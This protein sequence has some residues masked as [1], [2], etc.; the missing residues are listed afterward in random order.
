MV[1]VDT[2]VWISH[3]RE[4]HLGLTKLLGNG[5]AACRPFVVG[6]LAFENL[7]NRSTLLSLLKALP[8]ALL[9]DPMKYLCL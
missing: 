7:K 5:E 8:M 1:L 6:E 2:S 3:L 4:T 9:V